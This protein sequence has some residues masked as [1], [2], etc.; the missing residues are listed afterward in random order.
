MKRCSKCRE[1]KPIDGFHHNK[2]AKDGRSSACK[3]CAKGRAKDWYRRNP[4]RARAN[5]VAWARLNR[6]RVNAGHRRRYRAD[7]SR[8]LDA[9]LKFRYKITGDEFRERAHE[10]GGLCFLCGN[11]PPRGRRLSVDHDHQT[12]KVRKLL[13]SPCNQ[14]IGMLRDD[15]KLLRAAAK[16]VEGHLS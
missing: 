5:T 6:E 16:Y 11:T 13:C 8:D 1:E 9:K 7:P 2:N 14:G 12:G 3:E 10:Q 15:P 4:E